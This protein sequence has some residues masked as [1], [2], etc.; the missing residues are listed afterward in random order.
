MSVTN[1]N[2]PSPEAAADKI[3]SLDRLGEVT[4]GLRANG[5][6]V[7]MCHGVFD[8]LHLGHIKHLEAA[9]EFGDV[10]VVT[11]SS[12]RHVNKGPG[13]PVFAEAMR[14][15]MLAA[16]QLVD[17]VAV[18]DFPHAQVAVETVLP[19]YYVKGDEYENMYGW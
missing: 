19:S 12:D 5:T 9:K 18:S 4:R 3:V 2:L 1:A 13:R 7:V 10:L 8:L 15:E 16:L 6:R 17:W 11:I 14:A